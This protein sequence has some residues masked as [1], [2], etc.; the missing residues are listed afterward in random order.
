MGYTHTTTDATYGYAPCQSL[1]FE[2]GQAWIIR[3]QHGLTLATTR[4][5]GIAKLLCAVLNRQAV[6]NHEVDVLP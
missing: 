4:D 3:D 5:E 2:D 6:S 1:A